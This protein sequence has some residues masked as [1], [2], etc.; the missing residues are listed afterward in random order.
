MNEIKVSVIIP[1]YNVE[2]YIE[3]CMESVVNQTLEEIEIIIVNDGTQDN[4][5]KKIERFLSDKRIIVINK[6]NGGLSSAR[7]VGLEIA[8][9]EFIA[10]VDSDD[11]V[12]K[13]FLE[14]LYK[15][16]GDMDI[17][18]S[19]VIEYNDTINE[20]KQREIKNEI[21]KYNKGSYFWRYSGFEVW[22][23]IYKRSFLMK[24]N[25][26]F[27]EGIIFEDISFNFYSL[28]LS[29]KVKY[30]NK[31]YYY[32]RTK[33]KNSILNTLNDE[34]ILNAYRKININLQ[35]FLPAN[36][37]DTFLKMRAYIW[38]LY[39][40]SQ[41]KKSKKEKLE[42]SIITEFEKSL[43]KDYK[44]LSQIEKEILKEDLR[45]VLGNGMFWKIRI[46]DKF[47]WENKIFTLKILRRILERKLRNILS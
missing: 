36:L 4:S 33:R 28:F 26:K 40:I 39:Y 11:F 32:Y 35:N 19:N 38:K 31:A 30:V 3:E 37:D 45:S 9:G 34:K 20:K 1:V 24:N 27:I 44:N 8:R 12:D 17:I 46:Y 16:A 7:N 29:D 42:L 6:E 14:G 23:K 5:M 2:K 47:Y 15:N 13:I 22:N 41:E 18:I 43:K 25:I 21:I 10:F